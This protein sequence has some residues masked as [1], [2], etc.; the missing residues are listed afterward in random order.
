VTG[1]RGT[2]WRH[3]VLRADASAS[4]G[5]GHLVRSRTLAEALM[6]RG[7]RAT[8]A[9]REL[10]DELADGL[11]RAGIAIL[12]VSGDAAGTEP[13]EIGA[14]VGGEVTLVVG[15]HYGLDSDWFD[16]MRRHL[17]GA[18]LMAIDDL[19]DRPLPVDLVLDQNLGASAARY[20]TLVPP[21]T[22]I[23]AGPA[24][25]L[26]RPEFAAARERG[27]TRDG[28]VERILI[29]FSGADAPD[30]TSRAVLGVA[31]IGL[32]VDVVVGAAYP[33]LGGLEEI[34][35]GQPATRLHVNTAAMAELMDEAD[36]AIGAASS[37]SW[38]RCALGLP[39]LLVTLADNQV[40]A[41]RLLVEAGA[42]ESIGWHDALTAADID[43]AVRAL[44]ADPGRVAGMASAAAAVTDGRGTERVVAEI[45][46]LVAQRV[47]A[48]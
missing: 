16:G 38:E 12:R 17:P 26:L 18:A 37:A 14:G 8:I 15:D 2:T 1:G 36:L 45:E 13:T 43:R 33:H 22:R 7:W 23:L 29:F 28:T 41:E 20:A 11:V 5:T 4:I 10:P 6:T 48:T 21:G 34:V 47:E 44:C 30:V 42:A 19:A 25:A 35:A 3:V 46:A 32:P 31:G 39:A 40:D 9:T 27:R 24:Y